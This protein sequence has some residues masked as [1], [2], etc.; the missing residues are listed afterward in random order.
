M[1]H[2]SLTCLCCYRPQFT[3]GDFRS[4]GLSNLPRPQGKQMILLG[5]KPT[6]LTPTA[7]F[8]VALPTVGHLGSSAGKLQPDGSIRQVV[9]ITSTVAELA[10]LPNTL[11]QYQIRYR[12]ACSLFLFSGNSRSTGTLCSSDSVGSSFAFTF[13]G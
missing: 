7:T 11:P 10:C 2:E 9:G 13:V 8:T 5:L 3:Q 4:E 6:W 12:F 1:F